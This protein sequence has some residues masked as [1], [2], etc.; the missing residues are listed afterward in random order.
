[1][2]DFLKKVK[3]TIINELNPEDI[4]LIDN[5]NLHSKH[6]S[7]EPEK[8]HLKLVIK[9]KKLKKMSK[10]EAHKI[11]F[12]IL[13]DEMKDKIHALEIKIK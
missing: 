8:F 6:Q 3:T 9:S 10:I 4:L 13:K 5:S 1:M 2:K 11:I 7:F 12:S